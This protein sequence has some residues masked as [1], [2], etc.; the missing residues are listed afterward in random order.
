MKTETQRLTS[1]S[2]VTELVRDRTRTQ[3]PAA[4]LVDFPP[5]P[6]TSDFYKSK[7]HRHTN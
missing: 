5:K 1:L 7:L 4:N 6:I 2:K 3:T